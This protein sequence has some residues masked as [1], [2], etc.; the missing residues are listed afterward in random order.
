MLN[1]SLCVSEG[2]EFMCVCICLSCDFFFQFYVEREKDVCNKSIVIIV[3]IGAKLY[4]RENSI[5]FFKFTFGVFSSKS[6]VYS[7]AAMAR[8]C[9]RTRLSYS[10]RFWQ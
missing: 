8:A 2:S 4:V 10:K 3:V 7:V 6:Y 5:F 1:V 9:A